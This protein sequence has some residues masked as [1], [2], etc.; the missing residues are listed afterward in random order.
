MRLEGN[1][2]EEVLEADI[3]FGWK[4]VACLIG[5]ARNDLGIKKMKD[6]GVEKKMKIESLARVC[7]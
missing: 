1:E 3:F 6:G 4:L 2:D 7:I 5:F